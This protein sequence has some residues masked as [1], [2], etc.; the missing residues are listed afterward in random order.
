MKLRYF[1]YSLF[2][3]VA[4]ASC[5]E[6]DGEV[7][8]YPDWQVTNETYYNQLVADVQAK[9]AAGDTTWDLLASYTK[10]DNNYALQG[11]DYVVVEKLKAGMGNSPLTTDS[12][13]VSYVGRLLPSTNDK[14]GMVFD[15]TFAGGYDSDVST[16]ARLA[17]SSLIDGFSTALLH[18]RRGDHWKVYIPYQLG[19]GTTASGSIPAYSTLIFDLYLEDFWQ[20]E[21]GDRQ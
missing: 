11:F 20:K 9:K 1:I 5:S 17:V 13:E 6:D 10:A 8:E 3:V 19:Y 14:G 15:R 2:A 18:M 16:P 7:E 12:V 21:K 4:L